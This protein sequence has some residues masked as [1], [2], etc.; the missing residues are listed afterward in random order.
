MATGAISE[1]SA[2][3]A[4]SRRRTRMITT[5]YL[6]ILPAS[7]VMALITIF[8]LIFQLWMSFTNYNNRNLRTDS[9]FGQMLGSFTGNYDAYNSPQM[10]GLSNYLSIVTNQLGQVLSGFDFWRMLSFNLIWTVTNVFFHVIIGVGVAVLLNQSGLWFKPFYRA[11]Y[12]LPWAMPG[13]VTAMI[14]KNM[15]DSENGFVN[16]MLGLVGLPHN[17]QWWT[18]LQPPIPFLPILPLSYFA[19]LA[20]NVWLGWPFMMTVATGALQSIPRELYEA[21]SMDG[22]NAWQKFWYVTA[23]LIRP[24]MVPAIIIGTMMTFN[25]FSVIY[26]TSGGGPLHQTEILV[27]QAY[28]LV[29]ETTVNIPG[30]GNARPYGLAAAFAYIVFIVLI[31]LTLITNRFGRATEAYNE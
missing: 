20:T 16:Q 18:Q 7:I 28:R 5:A 23:P 14:W 30:V 22:A 9:L 4:Q 8:P 13:L 6:Y 10:V 17:I 11:V 2:S 25:Q 1:R 31:I 3:A 21:A 24:A 29:N 26:F 19:I 15:F 12:I 27:T